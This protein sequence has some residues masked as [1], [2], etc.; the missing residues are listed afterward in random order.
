MSTFAALPVSMA[1]LA[2]CSEAAFID[3]LGSVFEHS[4]G[5]ARTVLPQRP[6]ASA[7]ALHAS[8]MAVLQALPEGELV[9]LLCAHPELAGAQARA[10]AMTADSHAEQGGLA[11]DALGAESAAQWDRLN[12]AYRARFGFP[13]VLCIR[14]HTRASA[15][16]AFEH[17]LGNARGAEL[18]EA[19]AEIGR[20]SR[21]RLAAR[22]SDHALPGIHG[23]LGTHVL[24]LTTGR[25]AHG[26]RVQLFEV[27]GERRVALVDAVTDQRG[28]VA[29]AADAMLPGAPLRIGRYE[30]VFHVA[31]YFRAAGAPLGDEPFLD[32]VPVAFGIAEPEGDYHVPLTITPWAYATYRGS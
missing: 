1:D 30:L 12:A 13:F 32:V 6:F 3:G 21:L 14:R 17:R 28:M 24:D 9:Q 23:T 2:A 31:A 15:L 16:R 26:L 11:L 25:P 29:M 4:A 8:M 22:I 20:I 18:Q 5:V 7:D 19:L 27:A 10:G